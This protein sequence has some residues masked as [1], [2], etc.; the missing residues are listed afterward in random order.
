LNTIHT[1]NREMKGEIQLLKRRYE[2][3]KLKVQEAENI[4]KN[5]EIENNDLNM[6]KT[7][8]LSKIENLEKRIKNT[9]RELDVSTHY[10]K[11]YEE[12]ITETKKEFV[13]SQ[14]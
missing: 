2:E 4:S 14:S 10:Y 12:E 11:I 5:F 6:L 9:E 8:S 3:S 7:E 13:I 1:N